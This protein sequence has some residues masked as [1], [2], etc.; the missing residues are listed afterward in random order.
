M[1]RRTL[2]ATIGAVVA[3]AGC[4]DSSSPDDETGV[5]DNGTDTPSDDTPTESDGDDAGG[6]F[7]DIGCPSFADTADRTVCSGGESDSAVYPTVSEAVFT[8][9][10]DDERVKTMQITVHNES[11]TPFGFNPYSWAIKRQTEDGWEHVAPEEYVEPWF[12]LPAGETYTWELT[13]ESTETEEKDRLLPVSEDLDSGTYA[14]QITGQLS[15]TGEESAET[16]E[17]VGLF[18]V[19]R[20]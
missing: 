5:G 11:E 7:D 4:V 8:P 20:R 10:T 6:S 14:F 2:L 15:E 19:N 9:T 12:T 13:V 3:G 17:C 18:E 16:I 1:K